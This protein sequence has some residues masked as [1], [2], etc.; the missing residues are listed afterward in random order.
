VVGTEVREAGKG[1]SNGYHERGKRQGIG[2]KSTLEE[3]GFKREAG[4][5]AGTI[6]ER[7]RMGNEVRQKGKANHRERPR[8]R[9]GGG[10]GRKI[11]KYNR[12]IEKKKMRRGYAYTV[13]KRLGQG[14]PVYG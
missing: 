1:L 8:D 6:G 11:T 5:S 12:G 14:G 2:S 13:S 3:G 4:N 7:L 9:G 10:C